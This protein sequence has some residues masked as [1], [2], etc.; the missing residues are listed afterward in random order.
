[1]MPGWSQFASWALSVPVR[2][3]IMGIALGMVV[4]LGFGVTLQVRSSMRATLETEL[5]G[6]GAALAREVA[7]RAAD[8]I[9]TNNLFALHELVRSTLE[10]NED[11]C[12]VLV[13]DRSGEVL[14]HTLSGRPSLQLLRAHLPAP[15]GAVRLQLLETEEG[16]IYDAAT[17][18]LEGRAGVAR[19]GMSD[20]RIGAIVTSM[21]RRLLGVTAL[22]S[23]GGVAAAL[24]LTFVL[25]RPILALGRAAEAV[26]RGE[27][28]QRAPVWSRDEIGRLT[29]AFNAM[30]EAL[31]RSRRQLLRRNAELSALNAI[32]V[33]VSRS[34][35]LEEILKG[36]LAEVLDVMKL[37]A[38]WIVL[39]EAGPV[40]A[41]CAGISPAAAREQTAHA[42]VPLRAKERVLGIMNVVTEEGHGLD[43]EDLN[44]LTAIG[45]Q[46]G[47]AVENAR[48]YEEVQ[49]KEEGRRQLLDKLITAQ[50]EERRRVSRELHDEIGQSLTA[51][52][53]NVGSAEA[54]IPP[55]SDA[56]RRHLGEIQGLLAMT[57]EEIRRLMVDL[58][59]TLL[60]DLGLIPAI[61]WF[62]ETH[63]ARA[64]IEPV[65][66]I[67]GPRRR[68]SP[69]VETA[70]FRVVQEAI[71]N[72]VRHS[73]AGRATVRL[74]FRDGVVAAEISDDGKG[75]DPES[76]R[77]GL[78][79]L[80]M[81]ER[82]TLLGGRWRIESGAGAGTRISIEIPLGAGG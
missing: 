41:A 58:R 3:K 36:A 49:R 57:L 65:L 15:P 66:K 81:E 5:Q 32:A 67:G 46:I 39:E 55:G 69:Q 19:V 1:M 59:P 33:A 30:T 60:D 61:Q 14:A 47:M 42:S 2:I 10:H 35:H 40:P 82:V 71:T 73:G 13:L 4:L 23:L 25:T 24:L 27:F 16:R 37:R 75:F 74:E 17:P 53:M 43:D 44:L 77:D 9:V 28:S 6:R 26:G 51:L 20:R 22:V 7:G 34:L 50:E 62:A 18:I 21:T 68:L 54:A 63:L 11:V 79:L 52:I 78:G 31:D 8:L 80:G 64:G 38:G 45:H 12:Y 70:L 29:E 76:A 48:L 72:I 56:L